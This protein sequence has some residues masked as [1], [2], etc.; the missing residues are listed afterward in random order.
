[1]E[2]FNSVNG[3][4]RGLVASALLA[5]LLAGCG[6]GGS[7]SSECNAS[8]LLTAAAVSSPDRFGAQAAKLMLD[9]GGNAVDAGVAVAFALSVTLPSAGNIGGGGFMTVYM[10]GKPYFIDY[11]EKAPG[12]ATPTMY[13]DANGEVIPGLSWDGSLSAGVPGTVAGMQ[14]V[15]Q[16][17]GK[18]TWKQ[19]MAP[20]IDYARNGFTAYATAEPTSA[21]RRVNFNDYFGGKMVAGQLF[22]Q[23]ELANTLQRISD[24]G[25]DEFYKGATADLLVAQ[26]GRTKGLISKADLADYKPVWR[27]PV[28]IDWNGLTIYTSPPPS[29]GGFGIGQLLKMKGFLAPQFASAPLNSA[30]YIHL[31]AEMEKRLFADRAQ[32]LGDPDFYKVPMAQLL[33]DTYLRGRAA[34]VNPLVPT[35]VANVK[36]GLGFDYPTP[37][38]A[39]EKPETTHFSIVDKWGNA[40]SNT[41]TLNGGYGSGIVV[42][43]AGFLLNNE[44]DDFSAKPGVPNQ[45]GVVGADA[46]SIQPGKRPLSSMSP[47]IATRDGKVALVLGTPGGSRIFTSVYQVL[48]NVFDYGLPI[49]QAQAAPRF[50]HQLLPDNVIFYEANKYSD[51]VKADLTRRGW[52]LQDGVGGG[53]NIEAIQVVG[54]TPMPVTDPRSPNGLALVIPPLKN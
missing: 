36:P 1:M 41:Y 23:P 11:R 43:G 53:L 37:I 32:Y 20:A 42:E 10:D 48:V 51:S 27:N 39:A 31:T 17:F 33:D 19:V 38:S 25:A 7:E 21:G 18:L 8:T 54:R 22:K 6:G 5:A 12:K 2:K 35:P 29:S 15:H 46:N 13:L 47:T 49:D 45:Y 24:N 40:V 44:M 30:Q 16:K 52:I 14:A 50:H 34:S 26:M 9:Q 28:T 3:G 4:R